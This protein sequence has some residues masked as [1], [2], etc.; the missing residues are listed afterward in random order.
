[1]S[2]TTVK[3]AESRDLDADLAICEAATPGLW[4]VERE[5]REG[6]NGKIGYFYYINTVSDPREHFGPLGGR[7]ARFISEARQGWPYAIHLVKSQ[8]DEIDRL[9]AERD[10]LEDKVDRLIEEL[11]MERDRQQ[12]RS[13]CYD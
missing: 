2:T 12:Y 10:A 13:G 7:N 6:V 1:M 5:P 4:E 3:P 9:R 8:Q 11:R